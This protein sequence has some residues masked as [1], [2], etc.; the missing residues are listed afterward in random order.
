MYTTGDYWAPDADAPKAAA[1]LEQGDR[2]ARAAAWSLAQASRDRVV[3]AVKELVEGVA[4]GEVSVIFVFEIVTSVTPD[5]WICGY[6]RTSVRARVQLRARKRHGE[7]RG[8]HLRL[9]HAALP[10]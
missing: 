3:A 9:S 8:D 10:T 7:T 4:V 5:A 1:G 2:R 6:L